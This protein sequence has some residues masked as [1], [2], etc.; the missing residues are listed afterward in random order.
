MYLITS[1]LYKKSDADIYLIYLHI[2]V[3]NFFGS[4]FTEFATFGN[5]DTPTRSIILLLGRGYIIY[6]IGNSPT[7][8]LR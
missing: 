7:V 3:S 1:G 6:L 2:G 5:V 8:K 4:S